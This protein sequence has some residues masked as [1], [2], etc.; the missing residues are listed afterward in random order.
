[1]MPMLELREKL[2]AVY[3]R[4]EIGIT[5]A[6][7]MLLMLLCMFLIRIHIG[8]MSRLKNLFVIFGISLVSGFLPWPLI[9][10]IAGTVILLHVSSISLEMTLVLAVL[11]LLVM[12]LYY[13]FAPGDSYLLLLTPAAFYLRIPY[14]I[15]ILTGLSGGPQRSIPVAAA[16]VIY[17]LLRYTG[18]NAGVLTNGTSGEITQKLT[19]I[20]KALTGNSEMLVMAAA[21]CLAV[22][23]VYLIRTASV[24]YAWQIAIAV[25]VL[26]QFAV[27]FA[28]DLLLDVQLGLL[29]MLLGMALS[30][31]LALFYNFMVFAVDYSATEYLTFEDDD[32]CYYVK[33]VPKIAVTTADVKVQKISGTRRRR[34][35]AR[36]RRE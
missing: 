16:T 1:M 31:A 29:P 22:C 4:Y 13:G 28:G 36:E 21:M 9:A 3:A 6:A 35:S 2:R 5:A 8:Y 14:L 20:L 15:P 10:I 25:G 12:V 24:D 18:D 34:S 32:Y 30:A 7:R 19:M 23:A 11:F 17:Y 27:I 33:A 26:C